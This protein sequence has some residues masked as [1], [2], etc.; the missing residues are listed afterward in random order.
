M[1]YVYSYQVSFKKY[2]TVL[3]ECLL[4]LIVETRISSDLAKTD[5]SFTVA[6]DGREIAPDSVEMDDD[7]NDF[8]EIQHAYYV[9]AI[10]ATNLINSKYV[11]I[12]F[13]GNSNTLIAYKKLLFDQPIRDWHQRIVEQ[14]KKPFGVFIRNIIF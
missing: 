11:N 13:K 5:E 6:L 9:Y 12:M 1:G 2:S 4:N 10:E 3:D 8:P 7:G 14:G